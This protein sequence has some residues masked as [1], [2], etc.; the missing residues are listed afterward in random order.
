MPRP[1]APWA[2]HSWHSAGSDETF[3]RMS[4]GHTP[5]SRT[6]WPPGRWPQ[7]PATRLGPPQSKASS[8]GPSSMA[9][10]SKPFVAW[11]TSTAA[12]SCPP[13]PGNQPSALSEVLS[14]QQALHLARDECRGPRRV[15][16]VEQVH[17]LG[18][19]ADKHPVRILLDAVEDDAGGLVGREDAPRL[20][21]GLLR[22]DRD[23]DA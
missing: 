23:V 16:A 5:W 3:A 7:S 1:A 9:P 13:R 22:R 19:A 21:L 6:R 10:Y 17:Q 8:S 2:I 14:P 11:R 18:V 12:P 4:S 15:D 20:R